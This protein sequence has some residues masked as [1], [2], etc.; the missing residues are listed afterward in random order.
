MDGNPPALHSDNEAGHWWQKTLLCISC[1]RCGE[2][3]T[4]PYF[5]KGR[6]YGW[7]CITLVN[8]SV[9]K[10]KSANRWI[11]PQSHN[12]DKS[13]GKQTVIITHEAHK[14]V[15]NIRFNGLHYTL[16]KNVMVGEDGIYINKYAI[17]P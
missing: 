13:K 1:A 2:E 12:F 16:D 3:I 4:A 10:E 8:P 17:T 6:P 15:V 11:I 9:K 14:Y 7:T 5:Y